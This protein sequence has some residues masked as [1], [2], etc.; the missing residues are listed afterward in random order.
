MEENKIRISRRGFLAGTGAAIGGLAAGSLLGYNSSAEAAFAP[1][2]FPFLT[3]A[4]LTATNNTAP[5]TDPRFGKTWLWNVKYNAA[6]EYL[7][8]GGC[9]IGAWY[10]IAQTVRDFFGATANA[11]GW[12]EIPD[13]MFKWGQG[14]GMGWGTVC[15]AL[16]GASLAIGLVTGNNGATAGQ[17]RNK[18]LDDVFNFYQTNLFPLAAN[19]ADYTDIFDTFGGIGADYPD[20]TFQDS[21]TA[22]ATVLNRSLVKSPLCHASVSTWCHNNPLNNK[23]SHAKKARCARLTADVA[24]KTVQ[25]LAKYTTQ[26]KAITGITGW[27]YS[28]ETQDC[29]DCHNNNWS[30]QQSAAA[31]DTEQGKMACEVCHDNGGVN[32][33]PKCVDAKAGAGIGGL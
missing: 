33:A 3:E 26:A 12:N 19:E 22:T 25:L 4:D 30:I 18:I 31:M 27:V 20:F 28:A 24:V 16:N 2:S 10:G 9:C 32:K 29:V 1:G 5:A 14:G 15:G 8:N 6:Y 21:G 7:A 17:H 11:Y 13:M 23:D